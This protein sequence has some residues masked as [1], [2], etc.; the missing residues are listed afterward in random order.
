MILQ[1][2]Y[3]I[4][5]S[6]RPRSALDRI[7]FH[8]V[9][10][11]HTIPQDV[12]WYA[13]QARPMKPMT[14][15]RYDAAYNQRYFKPWRMKAFG[16]PLTEMEWAFRMVRRKAVYD[17]RHKKVPEKSWKWWIS[18]A[19][20]AALDRVR[21]HAISVRHTN[22]RAL[23]TD[24]TAYRDPWKSTEGFPFDYNQ[25]SALYPNTPLYISHYSRDG[26]WAFVHAPDAYGWVHVRDIARVDTRFMRVFRTGHYAIAV[27]DNLLIRHNGKPYSLVK[28][29][30]L[31][32]MDR[33]GRKLLLA[34]RDARGRARIAT[35]PRP[36]TRL[37]ARKPIAFTPANITYI[38]RQLKR[39]PYGWGGIAYGRDCSATTRDFF[40]VF[41]IFLRRNSSDQAKDGKAV[42]NI[43][44]LKGAAKKAAIL[45]HAKPFRSLLFVPGHIG[46]YIGRYKG[47][48]VM[49]HT[50]WGIRLKDFSKYTLAHTIITT[51]EPGKE[52][53]DLRRKSMMSNTLQKIINF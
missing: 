20:F 6:S 34:T 48:P 10:D 33:R 44:P 21:G 4:V 8:S 29:G 52:R 22:L 14:Q 9:K 31:F 19:N 16:E 46:I 7:R 24:T 43:K 42:I 18:N 25:N 26:R 35:L 38:A 5:P 2:G 1:A 45:T 41:G 53:S 49:M 36:S 17:R 28:L 15:L 47:E 51:T 23:P 11:M 12:A 32:P 27:R 37:I 40:G 13:R 30:T 39:D 50:Y 3:T